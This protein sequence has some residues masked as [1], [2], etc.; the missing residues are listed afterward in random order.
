[1]SLARGFRRH[2]PSPSPSMTFWH[3]LGH[4]LVE[5]CLRDELAGRRVDVERRRVRALEAVDQRVAELEV[6]IFV[7]VGGRDGVADVDP[8]RRVLRD[9]PLAPYRC[10]TFRTRPRGLAF[11]K[12][13]S[14]PARAARVSTPSRARVTTVL[15]SFIESPVG[16]RLRKLQFAWHGSRR[17][18]TGM[19]ALVEL[20]YPQ[21]PTLCQLE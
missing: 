19:E 8:R 16:P 15:F 6:C 14:P 20:G 4:P 13:S 3:W 12:G 18:A 1:M 9:V 7:G 21:P 2:P 11:P 5:R 10:P 17:A